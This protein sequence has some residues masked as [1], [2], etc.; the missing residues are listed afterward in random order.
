M[1]FSI[2]FAIDSALRLAKSARSPEN[3]SSTVELNIS[4]QRLKC[5]VESGDFKF[6][7]A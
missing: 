2:R 1:K 3:I 6:K 7:P 4:S 5:P